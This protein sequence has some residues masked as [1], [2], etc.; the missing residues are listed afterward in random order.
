MQIHL[1]II[2]VLLII[3]SLFH[4]GFPT[5]FKWKKELSSLSLVNR[6]MMTIHTLFIAIVVFL[7]GLLCLTSSKELIETKLGNKIVLGIAVFWSIRLF[8]QFFGYSTALWKGKNFET[9][10]HIIFSLLW[11]YLSLIFWLI[12][13]NYK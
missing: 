10:I 11:F 13:F 5:Y 7:M 12:Y 4:I 6:Q 8:I 3:L 1:Q 2:G 9:I